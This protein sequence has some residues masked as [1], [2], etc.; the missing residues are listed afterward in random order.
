M[1][2][3]VESK[4]VEISWRGNKIVLRE[5]TGRWRGR[6][7][8]WRRVASEGRPYKGGDKRKRRKGGGRSAPVREEH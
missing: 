3:Q 8:C 2:F 6:L 7:I 4:E 5:R 1:A